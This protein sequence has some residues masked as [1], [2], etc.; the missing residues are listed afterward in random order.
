VSGTSL[1]SLKASVYSAAN[2]DGQPVRYARI[3]EFGGTVTAKN[4]FKRLPGGPYLTIPTDSNKTPAGVM[5]K[6]ARMLFNAGAHVHKSK[7]GNWGIF[8]GSKMMMVLKHQVKIPARFGMIESAEK[9]IPTV[10]SS[11]ANIIGEY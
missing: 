8:M 3:Q 6:D 10:L 11:L 2:V 5:R 9:E 7:A 4:A 1:A